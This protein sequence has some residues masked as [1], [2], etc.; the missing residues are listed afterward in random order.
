M[1]LGE[2]EQAVSTARDAGCSDLILLKCT[3]TY[4]ATPAN[5][6]IMTIPHLRELFNC[7]VGL[8]DHTMGVGTAIAIALALLLLKSTSLCHEQMVESIVLFHLSHLS[9]KILS[10]K[11]SM[12]G[13]PLEK[14]DMAQLRLRR[15]VLFLDVLYMYGR[16]KPW[17]FLSVIFGLYVQDMELLLY[18][19]SNIR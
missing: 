15:K 11:A 16:Y 12:H 17:Y 5:T 7:E 2:L 14:L 18:L 10:L 19:S 1:Q 13:C 4:P 3:S 6:N 9:S 8:S